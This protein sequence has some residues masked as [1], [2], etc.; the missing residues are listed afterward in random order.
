MTLIK[1]QIKQRKASVPIKPPLLKY[2]QIDQ[3]LNVN[4]LNN[5]IKQCLD[6]I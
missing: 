4:K 6:V 2:A 5:N 1:G 3:L